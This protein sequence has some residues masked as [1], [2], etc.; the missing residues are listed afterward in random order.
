MVHVQ[1]ANGVFAALIFNLLY[2]AV[3]SRSVEWHTMCPWIDLM[4]HRT[5]TKVRIIGRCWCGTLQSGWAC[6]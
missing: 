4:N 3:L 1:A 6:I 2:D 5:G